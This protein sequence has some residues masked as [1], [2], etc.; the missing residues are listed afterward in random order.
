MHVPQDPPP[1]ALVTNP[2]VI[3]KALDQ[4]HILPQVSNLAMQH[5][6]PWCEQGTKVF[7]D[8]C[9]GYST[10]LA[11]AIRETGSPS[12]AIDVLVDLSM[13]LLDD[14]FYEQLLRFCG[15]GCAAYTAAAPSCAE[16]SLSKLRPGGLDG[17]Q[18]LSQEETMQL[19][20]CATVLDRCVQTV[21]V[22]YIAGGHGHVEQPLGAMSWRE[23]SLQSWIKQSDCYLILLA[24]CG[25]GLDLN[26]TW[27]F[28]SSFAPLA[29]LARVCAHDKSTHK[30]I[31]GV[32]DGSAQFISQDSAVYPKE[33]CSLFAQK[34]KVLLRGSPTVDWSQA[35]SLIPIKSLDAQ[36]KSFQDGGGIPSQPDW[37]SPPSQAVNWFRALREHWIPKLLQSEWHKRI[38]AHFL[39]QEQHDPFP[40][41]LVSEFRESLSQFLPFPTI[42]DWTVRE[43]QPFCLNALAEVSKLIQDPDVH[44]FPC[45][46]EGVPTGYGCAIPRSNVFS[47]KD[48]AERP[49]PP[50]LSV[51]L[52]NWASVSEHPDI[53]KELVAEEVDK[54]WVRKYHGSV[55][56]AKA[57]F[58]LGVAVGKLGLALSESRP[59]RLVV[60]STICGTNANCHIDEHQQM[61][62]AKD[63]VRCYPLRECS[64]ELGALSL[65]VKAAHKRIVIHPSHHG[66]LGFSL[67]QCLYFYRVCPF[68]AIFSAHWWGRMGSFWV[69]FLHLLIYTSHALWLFVDDFLIVRPWDVLPITAALIALTMQAFG[70]PISW[71]KAELSK[72]A[73]WIGWRFNFSRGTVQL[74]PAKQE[75]LRKLLSD[76]LGH[77]RVSKKSL[78]R[79]IGLSLWVTQLFPTMRS[80]MHYLYSDLHKAP[81]TQYS[82]DPGFWINTISC[83]DDALQFTARPMGTAI[84]M[85]SKL[86]SVRHQPVQTLSDVRNCRLSERRIWI[87]VWDPTSSRRNLSPDSQRVLTIFNH[88]LQL[89]SPIMSMYPKPVFSGESAADACAHDS[90]CQIGG[91]VK[92][93]NGEL[94][95]FSERWSFQDFRD[96]EIPIS[97]DTQKDIV[98]YETLAQMA[99]L[100]VITRLFPG[101]RVSLIIKSLSDNTGAEAGINK[102]FTTKFP[103]CLFL[104]RLSLMSASTNSN[105][106]VSHIAGPSNELADAISRW[107]FDQ[108]PPYG[109]S[110]SGR[111]RISLQQLWFPR[112]TVSIHPKGAQVSWPLPAA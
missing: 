30:S 82:V 18:G 47:I 112:P 78:E 3:P 53:T 81:A 80:L 46:V 25:F 110:L 77:S 70:L 69:R 4:G 17:V 21:S 105:L 94:R 95:W 36:P 29:E 84:P 76:L 15:S 27:L 61:P 37:S 60:D 28:A 56:D 101:S 85:G 43:D 57:E 111:L 58:P 23:D 89:G 75:K 6:T 40:Q 96:M 1:S 39:K 99:L 63:V 49:Q 48:P 64:S 91:Y 12:L 74:H 67:D 79:F 87:R 32:K 100:F 52:T 2:G 93:S 72:S 65:D 104:E 8:V 51:H 73:D 13:D 55:E 38:A 62:S 11:S 106:D 71:R 34:I 88:W 35:L 7:L 98:C 50:D 92:L 90:L 24:A 14:Q 109:L 59:P 44:L 31:A 33:L 86:L 103:L 9:S 68:G 102:L 66:L 5:F 10:P 16:C 107:N 26:Q 20:N 97:E 42:L 45:L 54:G 22:T 83:L 41:E 108:S 19:Q